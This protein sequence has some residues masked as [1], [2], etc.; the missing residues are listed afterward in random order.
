[1]KEPIKVSL[2]QVL[3][4]HIAEQIE[5]LTTSIQSLE[6]AR[7]RETKS[8]VGDKYET[9]RAMMQQEIARKQEQ[10]QQVLET[11]L[12]LSSIKLE[13]HSDRV[14]LGS[15]VKTSKGYFYLSIGYGK[16]KLED[17]LYFVISKHSPIGRLMIGK[18][19]GEMVEFRGKQIQVEQIF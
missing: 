5:T 3:V 12:I 8:S 7:N 15:L 13:E 19:V 2:H 4:A 11:K 9:G 6:E 1:M 17:Q 18:K 14:V 10:L 16:L